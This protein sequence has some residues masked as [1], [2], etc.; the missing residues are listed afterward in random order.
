MDEEGGHREL[1]LIQS[2]IEHQ[3]ENENRLYLHGAI[4]KSWLFCDLTFPLS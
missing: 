1:V 3:L 2:A 4:E